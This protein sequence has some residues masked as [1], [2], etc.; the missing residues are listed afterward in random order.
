MKRAVPARGK[1]QAPATPKD[2]AIRILVLLLV[3]IVLLVNLFSHVVSV[4]HYYGDSMEP[5]LSDR[6]LLVIAKTGRVDEGDMVAFYYNNKVLVRRVICAGGR[7]LSI[8]NA[9]NVTI[10]GQALEEPY[11][12]TR[13]FGQCNLTFPYSVPVGQYFVMGDNRAIAMDSRLAEIGT[14]SADRV[15]GK[16]VFNL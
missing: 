16:V 11:V 4:V 12:S 1:H 3:V 7:E 14:I 6:Q 8:D 9:G 15:I 10:D 5:T 2:T 13:S